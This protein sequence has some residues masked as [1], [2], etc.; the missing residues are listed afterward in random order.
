MF[1]QGESGSITKYYSGNRG[2]VIDDNQYP[3][4]MFTLW[5]KDDREAIGIYEIEID[6]IKKKD[7]AFRRYFNK[8]SKREKRND[9][10][11]KARGG[12]WDKRLIHLDLDWACTKIGV[13]NGLQK[14]HTDNN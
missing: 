11:K 14:N 8:N 5:S 2:I 9:K 4:A 3:K 1:A 6:N 13:L 7:E 12:S 10:Q